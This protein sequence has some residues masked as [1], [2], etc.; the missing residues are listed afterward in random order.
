MKKDNFSKSKSSKNRL[1]QVPFGM[2]LS[3]LA[4]KAPLSGKKV[5]TVN[6]AFTSQKDYRGFSGGERKGCRFYASDGIV[7]D[8][9]WNASINIA[10][11][12]IQTKEAHGTKHPI[13]LKAPLDGGLNLIGRLLSTSQSFPL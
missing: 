6:P 11:K 4:Y 1:S 13:S 12:Y 8:A 2:L 3:I 7:F 9:D 5:A 10:K